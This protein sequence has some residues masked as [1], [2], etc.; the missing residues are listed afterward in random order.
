MI[1]G[2]FSAISLASIGIFFYLQDLWG[3][4][5]T[6]STLEWLP[7]LSLITFFVAYSGGMAN[8]PFIIMGEMFP[9]RFRTLLG[10]NFNYISSFQVWLNI[11]KY[12][13]TGAISS[14][15]NLLSTFLVVRM[16]PVLLE[17]IG[18]AGTFFLFTTCTFF[19]I[20]FVYFLLPETKG[21]TLED[22]EKLFTSSE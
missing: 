17:S 8:V 9:T 19:S 20:I 5:E 18:E 1:S 16:F 14:W 7:L 3:Y 22:M 11:F 21:K 12:F 2:F 10:L 15:V 13:L 6:T 4:E